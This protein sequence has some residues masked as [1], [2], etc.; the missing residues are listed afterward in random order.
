MKNSS[1]LLKKAELLRYEAEQRIKQAAAL[2]K[3]HERYGHI[4][5]FLLCLP[6]DTTYHADKLAQ[7]FNIR[8]IE[9][10]GILFVLYSLYP[11]K[12]LRIP[13]EQFSYYVISKHLEDE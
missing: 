5:A 6:E 4:I 2:E 12:I 11:G 7:Q 13:G 3:K 9:A 1:P 8:G 10:L